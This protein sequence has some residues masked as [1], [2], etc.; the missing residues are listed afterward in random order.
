[1][2]SSHYHTKRPFTED[3]GP[4]VKTMEQD[5]PIAKFQAGAVSCAVWQNRVNIDGRTT[6]I[7][8]AAVS[9]RYQDRDGLWQTSQSF[10]RNEVPMAIY[11][12]QKAFEVMLEKTP[13]QGNT[14]SHGRRLGPAGPGRLPARGQEG[15]NMTWNLSGV[16]IFS[17][18]KIL[19]VKGWRLQPARHD[20][21]QWRS[22]RK[23][24]ERRAGFAAV[25]EADARSG[26]D[27]TGLAARTPVSP[28]I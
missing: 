20:L 6:T 19:D 21:P 10:S 25:A 13:E 5:K 23:S 28:A 9:R 14:G 12:L 8:K 18:M 3:E 26:E 1:V 17:V 15:E 24:D 11:V 22:G 2:R 4:K 7:L 16:K 27:R